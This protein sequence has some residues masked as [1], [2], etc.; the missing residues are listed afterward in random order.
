MEPTNSSRIARHSSAAAKVRGYT[1]A[2]LCA[3][4]SVPF[5]RVDA[6]HR[7]TIERTFERLDFASRCREVGHKLRLRPVQVFIAFLV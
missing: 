7:G 5:V 6:V 4:R 2:P 1:Y 3:Y